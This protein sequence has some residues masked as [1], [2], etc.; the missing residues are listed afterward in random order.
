M[1]DA[2][3][4]Q[5]FAVAAQDAELVFTAAPVGPGE[6]RPGLWLWFGHERPFGDGSPPR[7]ASEGSVSSA[8]FARAPVWPPCV[9]TRAPCPRRPAPDRSRRDDRRDRDR[10][11]D[12]DRGCGG[13]RRSQPNAPPLPARPGSDPWRVSTTLQV[14]VAWA[15]GERLLPSA[16]ARRDLPRELWVPGVPVG[17]PLAGA[18]GRRQHR[19]PTHRRGG[20]RAAD[21]RRSLE[22]GPVGRDRRRAA[23]PRRSVG[24]DI[25]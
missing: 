23:H 12:G 19:P 11:R 16:A 9:A 2:A 20:R 18:R 8:C 4:Q 10:D 24:D 7:R 21:H 13:V 14:P 5:A 17:H 6:D 15:A 25:E 1:S 22:R 3:L